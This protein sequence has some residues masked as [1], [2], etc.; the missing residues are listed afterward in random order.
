[1]ATTPWHLLTTEATISTTPW[2]TSVEGIPVGDDPT[3]N[4]VVMCMVQP[5]SAADALIYGRDTTTQVY[6]VFMAPTTTTGAAWDISPKDTI[7]IG[8]VAYRVIGKPVDQ[9]GLGV[10]RQLTVEIDTN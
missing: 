7:T 3:A 9:A 10:V 4:P 5:L 6:S 8:N 1:M 2:V